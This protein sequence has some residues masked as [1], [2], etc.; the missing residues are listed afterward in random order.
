MT[1]QLIEFKAKLV[2]ID[3]SCVSTSGSNDLVQDQANVALMEYKKKVDEQSSVLE[4][5]DDKIARLMEERT[6]LK[7][8]LERLSAR[9]SV[10]ALLEE[11]VTTLRVRYAHGDLC[12][13]NPKPLFQQ[14]ML[15]CPVCND[16]MKDT[17][18]TRCYHVFC[19]PCVKSRLQLRNR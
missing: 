1:Q 17:V 11:E 7:R 4:R 13:I 10:D 2:I 8:K 5:G 3:C 6:L 15:R 16:N 18:I 19:N 14:K 12:C 9:G